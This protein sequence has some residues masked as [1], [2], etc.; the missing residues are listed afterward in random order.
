MHLKLLRAAATV[1][2]LGGTMTLGLG[3]TQ[4]AL[5]STTPVDCVTAD[6]I[7]AM[8]S[9][10]SG[11]TLILAPHCTY[12]LTGDTGLPTIMHTLTIVGHDSTFIKRSYDNANSFSI[13]TVG[14]VGGDLTLDNVNVSNGGGSGDDDGG[15]VYMDPGTVTIN[16]GIYK[17]NNA[18]EYGGA[19]YNFHGTLTV[20]GAIFTN[21]SAE[22]GGAIYS[23]N[24]VSTA[25][26]N[27]D[28]FSNNDA[29]EYGGA[30]DNDD[31]DMTITGGN[32]RY[33]TAVYGG[34]IYNDFDVTISHTL[35]AMNSASDQGGG[36][37]ND[38][39]TVTVN[40]SEIIVNHATDGG[41]GIYNY[42]DG[43]VNLTGDLININTP[44]NCDPTGTI[45]GCTG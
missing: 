45:T 1:A 10:T 11:D 27:G 38:D 44:N 20:D 16:G 4:A 25:S 42:E 24:S 9:Y 13:F 5:A 43:I 6:L 21:N 7:S 39:E 32:F 36:I 3:S 29:S 22:Y 14:C 2:L 41:G 40:H 34:G 35:F 18:S 26:L 30:I 28:T 33:N 15:A 23:E 37:Y 17:D 19:I 31:N 8:T 12:W